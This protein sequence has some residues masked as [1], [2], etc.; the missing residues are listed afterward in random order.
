[1]PFCDDLREVGYV[2]EFRQEILQQRKPVAPDVGVGCVDEHLVEE[3]VD[4]GPQRADAGFERL[5]LRA[6]DLVVKLPFRA[7]FEKIER[8]TR[9]R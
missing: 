7:R 8:G 5:A 6:A 9:N 4:F 1:M 3:E 2:R